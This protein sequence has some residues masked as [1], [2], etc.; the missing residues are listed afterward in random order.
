MLRYHVCRVAAL[1]PART[2]TFETYKWAVHGCESSSDRKQVLCNY[3]MWMVCVAQPVQTQLHGQQ[4]TR[5]AFRQLQKSALRVWRSNAHRARTALCSAVLARSGTDAMGT[6]GWTP[7]E[8]PWVPRSTPKKKKLTSK[9]NLTTLFVESQ[10]R[11]YGECVGDPSAG[12]GDGGPDNGDR[13]TTGC[14]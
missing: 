5:V 6:S 1:C 10:Y 13:D 11:K 8:V 2:T 12:Q 4:V 14:E 7:V 3:G 9:K